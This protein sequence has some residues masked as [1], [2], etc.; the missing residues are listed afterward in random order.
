MC[1]VLAVGF[2]VECSSRCVRPKSLNHTELDSVI[3]V[4]GVA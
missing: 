2:V 1:S 3:S 4:I